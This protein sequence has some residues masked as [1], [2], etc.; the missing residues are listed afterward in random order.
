MRVAFDGRSLAA[1]ALRGWDRYTVGLVDALVHSGV[2]V[3]LFHGRN[4]KPRFEHVGELGCALEEVPGRRGL[5]WEQ[6]AVPRALRRGDFDLFHAPAEH[7]VPLR[8]SLPVVLT[9]HSVT[10]HSYVDLV[11][12]GQ[13][14]GPVSRYL[15]Y[16]A[17]PDRWT[18]ANAYWT[19]QVRS[20]SHVLTPSDFARKEVIEFLDIPE[21]R[22]TTTH[23]AVD[24]QFHDAPLSPDARS[25]L[26]D[27]MEVRE[28]YLLYVGG[29]E[30]HKN[31]P[32]LLEVFSRVHTA[33]PA[34]SLVLVGSKGIPKELI[35]QARDMGLDPDGRVRFL[36]DLTDELTALYDAATLFVTMSWRETFCLPALEAMT[37]GVPVVASQWGALPEIVGDQGC[38]IDPRDT[39]KASSTI[40]ELLDGDDAAAVAAARNAA[41]RFDW[42]ATCDKT[43]DVYRKV[44]GA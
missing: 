27:R 20:A 38:L 9:V 14:P 40:L 32:G 17:R 5:Y 10:D 39:T 7:G 33:R 22:V 11:A 43:I 3:T 8:T 4:T 29:F 37:R 34:Y 24:R 35:R 21:S 25:A 28:P 30:P 19:R 2:D 1:T 44:I 36:S 18:F 23:L 42:R 6:V 31:V 15:G 13:L 12:T 26:L 41:A 16:E